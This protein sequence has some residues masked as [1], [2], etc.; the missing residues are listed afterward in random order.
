TDD[1][2]RLPE[3]ENSWASLIG[4][5]DFFDR[6]DETG[7][8]AGAGFDF[9][10]LKLKVKYVKATQ[11]EMVVN[12][13]VWS[14][15]HEKRTL[16]ENPSM[17]ETDVEY[18][19][20]ILAFRTASYTPLSTGFALLS[21]I[22]MTIKENNE[23]LDEPTLR[24]S[25]MAIANLKLSEGVVLRNRVILGMASETVPT[26]RQFGI[27]GLGSVS[28]HDFKIQSGT[29]M[30]QMNSELI[31]TEDFTDT[32]FMVILFFDAGMAYSTSTLVDLNYI[33][34]HSDQFIQS[35]GIGFGNDDGDGKN[36]RINFAKQLG[37]DGPIEST[38]RYSFNF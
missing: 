38:V 30:G 36:M 13:N 24:M 27:G 1:E 5:Q 17:L 25:H 4:R 18:V 22:E 11:T 2:F 10:L 28:A 33:V 29:H 9:S 16:R 32:F 15:F 21:K 6:W 23:T 12:S 26:F 37:S 35:A 14:L 8:E 19:E 34:D 31:F 7:F 3:H 20:G